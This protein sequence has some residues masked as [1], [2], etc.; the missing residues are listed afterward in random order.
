MNMD[1]EEKTFSTQEGPNRGREKRGPDREKPADPP[2]P[3]QDGAKR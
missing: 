1:R 3:D 2:K